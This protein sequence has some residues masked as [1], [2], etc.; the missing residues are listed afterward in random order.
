MIGTF[1]DIATYNEKTSART[2]FSNWMFSYDLTQK[3]IS[4]SASTEWSSPTLA[5]DGLYTWKNEHLFKTSSGDATPWVIFEFANSENI[6]K[7]LTKL[8]ET[9]KTYFSYTTVETRVDPSHKWEVFAT[10]NANCPPK[11]TI[12]EFYGINGDVKAKFIKFSSTTT[13][14]FSFGE[15][16]ILSRT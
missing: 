5:Y 12:V 1:F 3:I 8:R 11:G 6:H 13:G 2:C 14:V 9:S 7:I 4:S 16:A 15:I 10:Y